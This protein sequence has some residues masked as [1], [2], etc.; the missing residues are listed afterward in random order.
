MD[1]IDESDQYRGDEPNDPRF[2]VHSNN[3][4]Q[5]SIS[6]TKSRKSIRSLRAVE[7]EMKFPAFIYDLAEEKA[8]TVPGF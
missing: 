8:T 2:K 1:G 6:P 5:V 3:H 7:V 4:L